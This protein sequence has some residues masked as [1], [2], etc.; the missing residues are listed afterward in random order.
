[1]KFEFG[2]AGPADDA[3]IRRLLADNP[4]PGTVTVA[5]EREPDYFLGHGV[6]GDRCVTAK[7][8][9][10][11]S[12]KLAGLMCF[13]E[14]DRYVG[15]AVRRVGYVGQI[16]VD[17]R[18]RG[19]LMPMRAT[20]FVRGL[21]GGDWPDLWLSAIV[22]DNPGALEI[23]AHKSRPS[24]PQLE[25]VSDIHTLGIFTRARNRARRGGGCEVVHAGDVGLEAVVR[26]L[27]EQGPNREFFPHYEVAHLAGDE[28]TPG[29]TP[30]DILV[31]VVDGE[32]AGVCA[33]WD[34]S[35]FKQ[36][37]VHGYR[38]LLGA[39]RPIVNLAGPAVGMK[40][41]PGVGEQIKSAYLSCL[42]VRH[43]DPGVFRRLMTAAVGRAHDM[44][45]DYLLAGFSTRDP[46]LSVAHGF[47][48][49]LYRSTMY[50]FTFGPDRLPA[51]AFDRGKVPCLEIAA[52]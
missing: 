7:A 19:Y 35:T 27:H 44:G 15:G 8:V 48:H 28:R 32:I 20:A 51:D 25:P 45:T 42:A 21:A 29:L 17:H 34:Q 26:F 23:F 6:M 13:A 24:F 1:M 16:R 31:A 12:G 40:R 30:Q 22:A 37:V 38:G 46:L 50:A 41:L 39:L 9:D 10:T 3:A 14:A 11:A 2:L 43:D 52:L 4:M 47:R 5:F 49:L 18:Y 36:T 33:V